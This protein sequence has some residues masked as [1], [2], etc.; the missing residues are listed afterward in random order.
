MLYTK[1]GDDGTTKLFDCPQSKRVSKS[2]FVFEALGTLDELNSSLG[3]AKALAKKTNDSIV[4]L[5]PLSSAIYALARFANY[6]GGFS[7]KA[8]EYY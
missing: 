2:D 7:E 3:Y 5:N 1:K 4:Y 6:Q 8:P